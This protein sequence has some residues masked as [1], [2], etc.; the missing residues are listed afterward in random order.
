[1]IRRIINFIFDNSVLLIAGAVAALVWDNVD[2]ASYKHAMH[3]PLLLTS[4][5]GAQAAAG[6]R[7]IDLHFLVSDILMAL[8][9]AMAGREVWDAMLPGGALNSPR[10]AATPILCAAGGMI[11]PATLFIIGAAC[12]GR[13]EELYKGWAV[14]TATDIAFSYMIARI[15]FGG[16]HPAVK[17]LLLLA[18]VDDALGLIILA[19]FY[20]QGTLALAWLLLSV[21]AMALC[22]VLWMFR[23]RN[24][25]WYLLGPGVLSWLGFALSGLHPALGLLPIVPMLPNAR[26]QRIHPG[27]N[28]V[29]PA[30]SEQFEQQ[31]KRPVE[32]ILGLFGLFNAGVILAIP[33][34][35]DA[36]VAVLV[37]GG[38]MVGKPLGIF[39]T[40]LVGTKLLRLELG[41]GLTYRDLIV[42]GCVAGIGFTVAL[43]VATVAFK[44]GSVQDAA[45]LGALLSFLAAPVGVVM[46]RLMGVKKV[47]AAADEAKEV[48]LA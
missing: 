31:L 38:L 25:V 26:R 27:W 4:H 20:P 14:P 15:V 19:V 10:K 23:I 2:P 48:P 17:F 18:I 12:F 22:V 28:F 37:L 34:S 39:L 35:Q 24:F 30:D 6:G 29:S 11:M 13:L 21:G 44:A 47:A 32:V 43:F 3:L 42:A 41:T 8:F 1:M 36:T 45:K 16:G 46:G 40:A 33:S 5:I 9:F 7:V